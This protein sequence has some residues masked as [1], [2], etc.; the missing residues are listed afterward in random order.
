MLALYVAQKV[1]DMSDPEL[2]LIPAAAARPAVSLTRCSSL[3]RHQVTL[4]VADPSTG[5][6]TSQLGLE[7]TAFGRLA[8]LALRLSSLHPPKTA[9]GASR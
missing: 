9:A 4:R 6:P 7:P 3:R 1:G 5:T 8:G 2:G